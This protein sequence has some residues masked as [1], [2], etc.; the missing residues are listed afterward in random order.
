M[1]NKQF[2]PIPLQEWLEDLAAIRQ[3]T[4]PKAR[5]VSPIADGI[6]FPLFAQVS[7]RAKEIVGDCNDLSLVC[8]HLRRAESEGFILAGRRNPVTGVL[9]FSSIL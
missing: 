1:I 4:A 7:M 3:T 8:D 2:S 9:E 5:I 6:W